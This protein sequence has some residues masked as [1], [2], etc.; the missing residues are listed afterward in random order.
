MGNSGDVK[1]GQWLIAL[2]HPNGPTPGRP[3]VL[4]I[5]RV[6]YSRNDTIQTDGTITAGDSGGPLLDLAG[7]VVGI[8]SRIS[9]DIHDNYHVPID[10]YRQTWDR[11]VKGDSWGIP[12]PTGPVLGVDGQD[13]P[14][15]CKVTDVYSRYPAAKAGI[16]VGDIIVSFA[17]EPV[18]GMKSLHAI[19][20]KHQPDDDVKITVLHGDEKLELK[21]TLAER[22]W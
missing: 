2:G 8:H 4:R 13:V 5:G 19:L 12:I 18:T 6:L 16:K 9:D 14:E 7:R 10:T 21:A 15:G 11:L 17:G 3:P 22:Q 1:L 20:D